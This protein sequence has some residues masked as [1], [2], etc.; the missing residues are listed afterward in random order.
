MTALTDYTMDNN[1]NAINRSSEPSAGYTL[2]SYARTTPLLCAS[3]KGHFDIVAVLV[4]HVKL[5]YS[6]SCPLRDFT[7]YNNKDGENALLGATRDNYRSI[8]Y[9][10]LNRYIDWSTMTNSG[11]TPL[12]AVSCGGHTQVV[13]DSFAKVHQIAS[14]EDFDRFIDHPHK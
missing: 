5:E 1:L 10:I 4:K 14:P 6:G 13:S 9:L 7:I 3:G 11:V 12:P 8:L 2:H